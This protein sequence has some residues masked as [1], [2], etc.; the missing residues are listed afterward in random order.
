MRTPNNDTVAPPDQ[1]TPTP[2][3][4]RKREGGK[5]GD[6]SRKREG[7]SVGNPT[8]GEAPSIAPPASGRGARLGGLPPS[9]SG[10]GSEPR[11]DPERRCILSRA[12]VARSE[13]IRLALAPDGGVLPDIRAKAPG[14]G[15][16]IGVSRHE[17]E[18]AMAKGRLRGALKHAFKGAALSIPDDL[19]QRIADGLERDLSDR[20]GLEQ[21]AG[22]LV[23]G[24]ERIEAA[25]RTGK[26]AMLLHAADASPGGAAKL[27][28]AWRVGEGREG[29]ALA[30]RRLP[31]D[32]EALSVALGRANV[33]HL[34]LTD[35]RAASRVETALDR[36]VH[37]IGEDSS[38]D[39]A[40]RAEP[41]S[42][43]TGD[44]TNMKETVPQ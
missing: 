41:S 19:P 26:V 20:L 18:T 17:L 23:L 39:R 33:V 37:Y 32:R 36:L 1:A 5:E 7:G 25:A 43:R 31:L 44:D 34:A 13:A 22:H 2:D 14:R 16:W 29:D 8:S 11:P 28:Q 38:D 40:N 35:P 15:A 3:P 9:R 42:A 6:P 30:G 21:R 4:S 12:P 10:V 24:S 27:D